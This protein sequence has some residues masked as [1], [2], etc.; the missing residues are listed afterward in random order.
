L[1]AARHAPVPDRTAALDRVQSL[2]LILENA[3]SAFA[4]TSGP[5]HTLTYANAAFR[6][7]TAVS[8]G[9]LGQPIGDVL[10]PEAAT[11]LRS[12]LDSGL[13]DSVTLH[14]KFLGALSKETD[15]CN[16]TIWPIAPDDGQ[17]AGLVI[18]LHK[19]PHPARREALQREV[20]ER[21]LLAAL[22]ESEAADHA[23]EAAHTRSAFLADA[24]RRFGE[25]LDE[26]ATRET[27]APLTLPD[28][29][30]WCIVDIIEPDGTISRLAVIHPNPAKQELLQELQKN[31]APRP[32]DAFGAPAVM[33]NAQPIMIYEHV[34]D[35][36][37][38]AA[39]TPENLRILRELEV[40]ALLTVPMVS[41]GQLLGALTFVSENRDHIYTPEE[42]EL[43]EGLGA[44]SAEALDNARRYGDALLLREL[45]E[46]SSKNQMRFLGTISHELRTPLNAIIGYVE[47]IT[48]EVH[49]PVTPAQRNDLE[50]IRLNQEHLLVLIND[51]L[52]YVRT[53]SARVHQVVDLPV[54]EPIARAFGL[55][56][57]LV[58]KKSIHYQTRP[59]DPDIR[60]HADPE[61]V[62]QILVNLLGNAVKFTARGGHITTSYEADGDTVRITVADTGIGI[63]L[64]KH[65]AIFE[66]FVQVGESQG[67]EGG[68]GLGLAISRDLAHAMGGN[69]TVRSTIGK[70]SCFTLILPRAPSNA[71]HAAPANEERA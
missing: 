14:E 31:W 28:L 8:D 63:A 47:V 65:E 71:E 35:A 26:A 25:S 13:T 3:P 17:P 18:E 59:V 1:V 12:L 58:R 43:A 29:A 10:L 67:V 40:G 45:A 38:A 51:L 21:L 60:V 70:G 16:C 30:A 34:D 19:A 4:V 62:E 27:L 39:H 49:G 41:R 32:G 9:L 44:R 11:R 54:H 48:E 53:G 15:Y 24:S 52:N 56:E 23:A 68:S 37:A 46:A 61:R 57:S 66:P 2:R 36:L 7:L 33:R 5:E 50:R 55:L 20:A 22:R 6:R 42:I 64:D 69:L